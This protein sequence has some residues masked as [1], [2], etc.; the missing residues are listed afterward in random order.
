MVAPK[1]DGGKYELS[2]KDELMKE[3]ELV[4]N[5]EDEDRPLTFEEF[6]KRYKFLH[7]VYKK[8]SHGK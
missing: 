1:T 8:D 6:D 2:V 5:C 3:E 7:Q 4:A